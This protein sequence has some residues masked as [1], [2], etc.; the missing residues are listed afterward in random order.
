[1]R[2]YFYR[3]FLFVCLCTCLFVLPVYAA[4]TSSVYQ[5][6]S[7]GVQSDSQSGSD[8]GV[9]VSTLE[10]ILD[11]L[12]TYSEETPLPVQIVPAEDVL[13]DLSVNSEVP[14]VVIG[15]EPPSDP[16]FYGSCWVTGTDSRLGTVTVY[17]PID[18][19]EG[20]FGIDSNGYLF[21][22]SD[23]S[24]SGY[25][26]DTYN[27]SVSAGGFDYPSYRLNSGSSWDYYDLHLIP[28]DSNMRIATSMSDYIPV[29]VFLPYLL[30]LFGGV[31]ILCFMK[32]S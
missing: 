11:D 24:Y 20:V 17:F 3:S 27:N 2:G 29:S 7:D 14:E 32:W 16:V 4:E 15:D 22:I 12:P 6:G 10:G 9:P 8:S 25:C 23:S 18:C 1:M 26:S 28:T 19:R 30:I 5:S 13:P 21:N 31:V